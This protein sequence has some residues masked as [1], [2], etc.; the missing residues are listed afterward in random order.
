MTDRRRDP[1]HEELR[2]MLVHGDPASDGR[3]PSDAEVAA[4]RRRVLAARDARDAAGESPRRRRRFPLAPPLRPAFAAAVAVLAL[5]LLAGGGALWWLAD[6]PSGP[7][8]VPTTATADTT[9][10]DIT[11]TVTAA[12]NPAGVTADVRSRQIQF[13]TAG[14][15]RIVWVLTADDNHDSGPVNGPGG[16]Q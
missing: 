11:G 5:A 8:S 3:A 4:M 10:E 6:G 1:A 7:G 2:R 9:G 16:V 15:T 14:G 12:G 13:E